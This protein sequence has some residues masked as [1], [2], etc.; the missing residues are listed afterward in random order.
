M[1]LRYAQNDNDV[2][3][4]HRFLLVVAAPALLC[5]VNI[6]KSL[7]EVIRVA[8]DEVALMAM[9]GDML[10]GTFGLIKPTWWYGDGEF[11][12]DRWNFIA[13]PEVHS[14]VG[15]LLDDEA[16]AI[17]DAAGLIFINQGKIR[18]QK[19]GNNFLM[20]PRLHGEAGI[21]TPEGN[22]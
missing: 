19:H 3:A 6:E 15:K 8:R 2:I 22:A 18:R 5:P 12:T 9:R 11:L 14:G 17:A 21:F 13:P 16:K 1:L 20:F 7:I 4:I 10:V